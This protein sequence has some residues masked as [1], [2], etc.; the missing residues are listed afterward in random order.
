MKVFISIV[1]CC[2]FSVF[3]RAQIPI[4]IYLSTPWNDI[5]S[6]SS[7][8]DI[9]SINKKLSAYTTTRTAITKGT[10]NIYTEPNQELTRIS[11][12]LILKKQSLLNFVYNR[13]YDYIKDQYPILPSS[14]YAGS[15]LSNVTIRYRFSKKLN[16]EKENITNYLDNANYIPEGKRLDL[17]FD[18]LE[19]VIRI[20]LEDET[21]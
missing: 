19:K 9:V 10:K 17:I 4:H 11:S 3:I 21:Y 15:K 5:L 18:V 6:K 1:F 8:G 20:T 13:S 16:S 7:Y 14:I 2:L 12:S